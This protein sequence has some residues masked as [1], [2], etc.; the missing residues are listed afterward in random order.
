[1][2][3]DAVKP[4]ER[5]FTEARARLLDST[6]IVRPL[7]SRNIRVSLVI[8]GID[9][10]TKDELTKIAAAAQQIIRESGFPGFNLQTS[11]HEL[12]NNSVGFEIMPEIYKKASEA[13]RSITTVQSSADESTRQR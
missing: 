10:N 13:I 1:M 4:D 8:P 11:A 6:R 2:E 9:I 7:Y 3:L 5:H 12:E